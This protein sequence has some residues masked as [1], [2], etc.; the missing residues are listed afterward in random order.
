MFLGLVLKSK[1]YAA[2][3]FNTVFIVTYLFFFYLPAFSQFTFLDGR[4]L[5]R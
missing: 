1:A 3:N 2:N 5:R 4:V